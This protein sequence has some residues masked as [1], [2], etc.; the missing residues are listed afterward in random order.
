MA[1]S[2]RITAWL[3]PPIMV[4]IILVL[5]FWVVAAMQP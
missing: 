5:V 1:I 2:D 4:P 3:V